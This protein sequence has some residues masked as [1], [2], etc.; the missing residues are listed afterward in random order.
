MFGGADHVVDLRDFYRTTVFR[1]ARSWARV[2]KPELERIRDPLMTECPRLPESAKNGGVEEEVV[3]T[4]NGQDCILALAVF[5]LE[6]RAKENEVLN[7]TI[8]SYLLRVT[9]NLA[10]ARLNRR[11][12]SQS[13]ECSK[14]QAF[15]SVH[16]WDFFEI[17]NGNLSLSEF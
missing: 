6:S 15:F 14:D 17:Q 4:E 3:M 16:V 5:L 12:F 9:H 11:K 2:D 1:I 13:S 10:R 7:Q 8:V